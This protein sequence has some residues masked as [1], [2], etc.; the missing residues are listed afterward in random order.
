MFNYSKEDLAI[1]QCSIQLLQ[2]VLDKVNEYDEDL[3]ILIIRLIL[4]SF[5]DKFFQ[6]DIN[7][8]VSQKLSQQ[9]R[10]LSS[11]ILSYSMLQ[12]NKKQLEKEIQVSMTTVVNTSYVCIFSNHALKTKEK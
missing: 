8:K 3:A 7:E 1:V 4:Y 12:Q 11:R 9:F 2:V 5:S 10:R 6:Q